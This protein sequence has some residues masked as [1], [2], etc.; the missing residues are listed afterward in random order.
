MHATLQK[1]GLVI[2]N[3]VPPCVCTPGQGVCSQRIT[4]QPDQVQTIVTDMV[5]F[6]A[7]AHT[8]Q[9]HCACRLGFIG[10]RCE[11]KM[12]TECLCTADEI[13]VPDNEIDGTYKCDKPR[14]VG[15]RCLVGNEIA[16]WPPL[17]SNLHITWIQLTAA[18]AA[19]A[20]IIMVICILII[21]R[22]VIILSLLS[23]PFGS[24]L[25]NFLVQ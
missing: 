16:C 9:P 17:F 5:T 11:N 7:P 24:V 1:A 23:L 22:S 6:V 20:F 25:G 3:N 14:G 18:S 8:H 13:C 15:D 2:S 10:K 12:T 21:C 4:W 19:L